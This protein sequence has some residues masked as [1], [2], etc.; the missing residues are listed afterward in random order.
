MCEKKCLLA[1]IFNCT[2]TGGFKIKRNDVKQTTA[3]LKA[4]L[5]MS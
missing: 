5:L 4:I 1:E 2:T 3:K